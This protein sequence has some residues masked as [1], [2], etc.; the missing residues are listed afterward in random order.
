MLKSQFKHGMRNFK[1]YVYDCAVIIFLGSLVAWFARD[2]IWGGKVPFFRDLSTYFY[3]LRFILA[4]SALL[5]ELPLWNRHLAMGFPILADVQLG[6]FYPP[7]LFF[8]VLSLF[9]A[10]AVTYVFH[11]F[12]SAFGAYLLWR[13]WDYC[14][15][16]AM[17]GAILFTLGGTT[18][19]LINLL[20]HFQSAV[21]LPWC[22]LAWERFLCKESWGRFLLV[23]GAC[24]M[25]LLAGSPEVYAMSVALL[26]VSGYAVKQNY[27]PKRMFRCFFWLIAI[28]VV[29][30]AV[31]SVQLLPAIELV[32]HS[33]RQ[34]PIQFAEAAT[35]SLNPW[36]LLNLLFVTKTADMGL[37]DGTQ[38]F[39]ERNIPFLISH[40]FGAILIFGVSFWLILGSA[41]E[42]VVI[43]FLIAS[44]LVVAF[45]IYTPVY[46]LL[47]Q[48]VNLF[49]SFRYPEKVFFL[50]QAFLL[51]AAMRGIQKFARANVREGNKAL[52]LTCLPCGVILILYF[53]LNS[54]PLLLSKFVIQRKAIALP[55]PWT[56][57]FTAS[58]LVS[59]ERQL[60][61]IGGFLL[62]FFCWK[63]A[64]LSHG[65][66][67][68]VFVAIVFIDLNLAHQG[69][70]Y[71]VEPNLVFGK[72][73]IL[74]KPDQVHNRV[75]YYPN[76][77]N[78]HAGSFVIA[79]SPKT[80]FNEIYSIVASNLLPNAGILKG[81]DYMQD[82]NAL[83]T[84]SYIAFLRFANQAEPERQIR[85][86]GALNVKYVI[87]FHALEAR[88]LTLIRHFPDNPSWLYKIDLYMPRAYMIQKSR[89]ISDP[90]KIMNELANG[91][92]DPRVEVFL[93]HDFVNIS[94]ADF[95]SETEIVK[96]S[97]R[98]VGV[99]AKSNGPG[100]L[101]LADTFYPGWKVYVD[102]D[103]RPLLRADYFFRAVRLDSGE[104][105]VEFRYEPFW[106]K[107]GLY[108]SVA[109]IL[110]IILATAVLFCMRHRGPVSL[111]KSTE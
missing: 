12:V 27:M 56:A 31:V 111:K 16:Q 25:Q 77:G 53:L 29:V 70:Q 39:F 75:F 99:H 48:K 5:G 7:H 3:P 67:K 64:Y 93:D 81:F 41:R 46:P 106:F 57:D 19:S 4:E 96:Y 65:L 28:N 97:H 1:P 37:A 9:D 51:M 30:L 18:I 35:W 74:E 102:G 110:M 69:F 58:A 44:S 43:G 86:L 22:V 38:L 83:A 103:A 107:I 85:L 73:T 62:L 42:K 76:G 66:F 72:S 82:I 21:W 98:S 108:I 92:F 24:V 36:S 90:E 10:V 94:R 89:K 20:N 6:I 52:A 78:L 84:S 26:I 49:Q 79:R 105:Y 71:L 101:V 2:M 87:S 45:G 54:E 23:V 14:R 13:H 55:S 8:Y 40:Y 61:L 32:F 17:I 60:A 34:Q 80:P 95:E 33:R 109:S 63:N 100:F 15:Y 104:H 88:G 68:G 50:T 91:D 59:L 11:Y 47:Y